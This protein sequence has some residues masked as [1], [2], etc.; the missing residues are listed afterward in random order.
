MNRRERL[1]AMEKECNSAEQTVRTRRN[2]IYSYRLRMSTS[3]AD[4]TAYSRRS[5]GVKEMNGRWSGLS[6]WNHPRF[7]LSISCRPQRRSNPA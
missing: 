2:H 6:V 5:K 3:D 4:S 7:T 1:E